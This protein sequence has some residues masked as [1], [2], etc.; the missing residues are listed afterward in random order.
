MI[1]SV[2]IKFLDPGSPE[3]EALGQP[4]R[5]RGPD[6]SSR[7]N[8]ASCSSKDLNPFGTVVT[9]ICLESDGLDAGGGGVSSRVDQSRG[10]AGT[11]GD[12]GGTTP[13]AHRR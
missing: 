13:A 11:E 4:S 3:P 10:P 9:G 8:S 6:S 7:K 1:S 2:R 12:S 5:S